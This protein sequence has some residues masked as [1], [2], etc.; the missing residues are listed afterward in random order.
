MQLSRTIFQIRR[1]RVQVKS[2]EQKD[3]ARLR[4]HG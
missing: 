4:A 2:E 3:D 1:H